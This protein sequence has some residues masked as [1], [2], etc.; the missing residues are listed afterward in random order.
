MARTPGEHPLVCRVCDAAL[1][2]LARVPVC[3]PCQMRRAARGS[4]RRR[5]TRAQL[6][7]TPEKR[8]AQAERMRQIWATGYRVRQP[9]QW[10]PEEDALLRALA[11]TLAVR[12]LAEV[13]IERTTGQDRT[14]KAIERRLTLLGESHMVS[15]YLTGNDVKRRL[16]VGWETLTAWLH[17]GLLPSQ[18]QSDAQRSFYLIRESDLVQFVRQHAVLLLDVAIRDPHL[19]AERDTVLRAEQ[20]VPLVQ[21]ARILGLTPATVCYWI[22]RGVLPAIRTPRRRTLLRQ[23][24]LAHFLARREAA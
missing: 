2:P 16:G 14:P 11:G 21:A 6:A 17:A 9:R 12:E 13:F 20:L 8:A 24:D 4:P 23:R 5:P 18:R 19:R 3:R 10:T 15:G 7:W 1:K 22:A